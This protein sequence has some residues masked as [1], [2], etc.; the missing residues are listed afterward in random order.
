MDTSELDEYGK[1]EDGILRSHEPPYDGLGIRCINFLLFFFYILLFAGGITGIALPCI[2]PNVFFP[3]IITFAIVVV[4]PVLHLVVKILGK[5]FVQGYLLYPM[6]PKWVYQV[7]D[8]MLI[9]IIVGVI[10]AFVLDMLFS[11]GP[12]PILPMLGSWVVSIVML[13]N[14]HLI[15]RITYEGPALPPPVNYKEEET[16]WQDF[17]D[18]L[19]EKGF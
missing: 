7:G 6:Q 18:R 2:W 16:P 9:F 15:W 3:I 5:V 1:D 10:A 14:L 8:G 12:N 13:I 11:G 17:Q 19:R 4:V